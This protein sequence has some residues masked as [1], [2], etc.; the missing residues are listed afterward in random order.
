MQHKWTYLR[1]ILRLQIFLFILVVS[2]SCGVGPPIAYESELIRDPELCASGEPA[3]LTKVID[4]DTIDVEMADGTE[5][6]V[7]Y[8]GID[9]AE[10]GETCYEEASDRNAQLTAG[11]SLRLI[12]DTNDRD[13]YGRLVRYICNEDDVFL[14]AQLIVEGY[15]KAYRFKPDVRFADYFDELEQEAALASRGCLF[16]NANTDSSAEETS[17]CKV[18]RN[19]TA[20]GDSCIPAN[21]VCRLPPGCACQG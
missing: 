19:G 4:G 21:Q 9:T 5:E 8:I 16:S 1:K 2:S 20:C 11:G 7:R 10:R 14:D 13:F 15:A 6:R 3:T 18:C 12:R 17:C